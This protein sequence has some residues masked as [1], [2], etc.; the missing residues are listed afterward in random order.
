MQKANLSHMRTHNSRLVLRTIYAQGPLSRADLTR[1]TQLTAPTISDAVSDLLG[2]G[3]VEEIGYGLS[4]GGKRPILLQVVDDARHLIGLD[5]G[6]GDFHGVLANL[7]GTIRHRI[8]LPLLERNGEAALALVY[9]LVDRL[10]A[11][12]NQP[13]LG[14][15]LGAPGLVDS[16]NGIVHRAVAVDWQD[17]PLRQLLQERYGLPVHMA[18]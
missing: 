16:A 2:Q 8:D 9:D 5:L 4:S 1:A 6:R 11:A 12:A 7:R 3:L 14:I 15:G 17:I 18:N 13:L 10:V